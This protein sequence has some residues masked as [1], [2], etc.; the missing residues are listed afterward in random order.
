MEVLEGTGG[1]GLVERVDLDGVSGFSGVPQTA[2]VGASSVVRTQPISIPSRSSSRNVPVS[3]SGVTPSSFMGTSVLSSSGL[4]SSHSLVGPA[5]LVSRR[6]VDVP[7][8]TQHS[9]HM[10]TVVGDSDVSFRQQRLQRESSLLNR[11]NGATSPVSIPDSNS[12][13]H[14]RE[15]RATTYISDDDVMNGLSRRIFVNVQDATSFDS[16]IRG[17]N[18]CLSYL[19]P[20]ARNKIVRALELVCESSPVQSFH[21]AVSMVSMMADLHMDCD[22]LLAG[23]LKG[24]LVSDEDVETN[25]GRDALHILHENSSVARVIELTG[26]LSEE[27][28]ND[29]LAIRQLVLAASLDWRAVAVE[30][31]DAA[32]RWKYFFSCAGDC[33]STKVFA[34]RILSLYAPLANQLGMWSLQSELEELAFEY[35]YPKDCENLRRLVGEKMEECAILL[36]ETKQKVEVALRKSKKSEKLVSAVRIKGRIK[37]LYSIYKKMLRSNKSF[38]EIYD[39]IA[40]RI[41]LDPRVSMSREDETEFENECCYHALSVI[42]SEWKQYGDG[43]RF[44][45]FLKDPK[46]NGYK[47]LHTTVV[48]GDADSNASIPLEMQIRTSRMHRFA[49]FGKAAHWL[50]KETSYNDFS[51]DVSSESRHTGIHVSPRDE[52]S[53]GGKEFV[54]LDAPLEI[55][56]FDVDERIDTHTD[57]IGAANRA[58]R[59][60]HIVVLSKGTLH[61][62]KTGSTLI[63]FAKSRLNMPNALW[64]TVNGEDVPENHQ[65]AMS[66][67]IGIKLTSD[68]QFSSSVPANV[69][70]LA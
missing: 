13:V 50:Y 56:P 30:L 26:D 3:S 11:I 66:D 5:S 61:F 32:V 37:G 22:A 31:V 36:E 39:M 67:I 58:L 17:L 57:F 46:S 44:K 49:E 24:A 12:R 10:K 15:A 68:I 28:E 27:V 4:E 51:L 14:L 38:E 53:F 16:H 7:D 1:G 70:M 35:L 69:S 34:E 19:G 2:F 63:D 9:L 52:F 48:V 33:P 55:D 45:D 54:R 23:A 65:L 25:V 21:R 8:R 43:E 47:S 20:I 41:V 18:S 60:K 42:H 64:L 62:I 29:Q 59:R 40:L 6:Y